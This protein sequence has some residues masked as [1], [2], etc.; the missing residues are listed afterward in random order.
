MTLPQ[1]LRILW[2]RRATLLTTALLVGAVALAVSLLLPKTW[3]AQADLLI[4]LG[5]ED[6]ISGTVAPHAALAAKVATEVDVITSR[7]VAR[8]VVELLSLEHDEDS[9]A[10]WRKDTD[11]RGDIG[12]WLADD[13]LED[14]DV[15]ADADA[16][17][18]RVAYKSKDP[19]R[20][21]EVA[22]SF[23]QA[24]LS[25]A[26]ILKADPAR[27]NAEFFATRVDASRVALERAKQQLS[28]FQQRNRIIDAT[29][30][31]DVENE[32][33][34]SLSQELVALESQ[35][36]EVRVRENRQSNEASMP[37]VL[38]NPVV[39]SLRQRLADSEADLAQ[40]ARRLG[41]QHPTYVSQVNTVQ[42]LRQKLDDEIGRQ[43]NAITQAGQITT[44]RTKEI[45]DALEAQRAKVLE[46]KN[47]RDQMDV[48]RGEIANA[49]KSFE[50]VS[51][52][53]TINALTSEN[54]QTNASV[55]SP[56]N[57]PLLP[58][59][60]QPILNTVI[61]VLLGGLI[62]AAMAMFGESSHPK[63]RSIRDLTDG[64]DLPVLVSLPDAERGVGG[65]SGGG[66]RGSSAVLP[67]LSHL[68]S[69]APRLENKS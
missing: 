18:I 23:V 24:Y 30:R 21:A 3:K 7:R 59:S 49:Q 34:A 19:A 8:N 33:L 6:A 32:R 9:I 42:V 41:E 66:G 51:E 2:A 25:T 50:L 52:R 5:G 58:S 20:A 44:R 17:V 37:E 26:M 69:S 67:R 57:E 1:I 47:L 43:A 14:L 54:R 15:R 56:A 22:N 10:R 13:L 28:D 45:A 40:M 63:I 55:L 35:A 36:A 11:G 12:N 48:M 68:G 60:P 53:G 27:Q 4:N 64:F 31:F 38:S 61:G 39:Q 62:G 46:L 16:S 29:E 65:G